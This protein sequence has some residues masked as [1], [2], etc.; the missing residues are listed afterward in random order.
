MTDDPERVYIYGVVREGCPRTIDAPPVSGAGQVYT[1]SHGGLAAVVSDGGL[2]RYEL[3][4]KNV[5]THQA[6]L[7]CVMAAADVLPAR[8]GTTLPSAESVIEELL[9]ERQAELMRLLDYVTGRIELGLKVSWRDLQ[10]AFG[11]VVAEDPGLRALRDRLAARRGAA[12][13]T[14]LV[15]LGDRAAQALAAKRSRE[16]DRIVAALTPFTV[17]ARCNEPMSDLMI[18]NGAFLMERR[19]REAFEDAVDAL[20]RAGQERL[21]CLVAGPLPPYNFVALH[22]VSKTE[23]GARPLGE[24]AAGSLRR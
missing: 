9:E 7:D 8:L 13:R 10:A 23:S 6:V 17:S 19:D 11:E 3:T 15:E 21:A 14:T 22:I 20:D 24:V 5:R 12:S 16:A 2:P 4:R 1:V 18:L